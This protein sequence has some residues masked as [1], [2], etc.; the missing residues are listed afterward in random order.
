M[1]WQQFVRHETAAMTKQTLAIRNYYNTPKSTIS[2][3]SV[4]LQSFHET[5]DITFLLE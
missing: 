3:P 4:S 5:I 1:K 2:F